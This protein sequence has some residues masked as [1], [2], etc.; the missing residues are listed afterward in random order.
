[1]SEPISSPQ[2]GFSSRYAK[3]WELF[4]EYQTRRDQTVR[5]IS[6]GGVS[7]NIIDYVKDG[8]D[9][10]NEYH[11]KPGWKEDWQQNVFDPKTRDKVI[12]ILGRL[13]STRMKPEI[14]VK[15]LSI[16]KNANTESR[17]RIYS[18]L[19]EAANNKN[20]DEERLIWEMYTGLSEGSVIGFESWKRDTRDVEYVKEYDPDT[21]EK[22]VEKIKY[23]AWDDVYGEIVPID[24][25]YPETI[26]TSDFNNGIKRCF[27]V[28]EMTEQ[29]FQ[30]TYGKFKNASKVKQA[31]T[32]LR[33][34]AVPWGISSDINPENIQVIHFYDEV[35]DKMG[36]WANTEELYFGA[37]PWNHKKKPFWMGRGEPIHN[38]YLYGKSFP[39]K[40]MGMQDIDNAILNGM[41]DELFTGLNSPT[42]ASGIIDLEEGYLEPNRIYEM[43]PGGKVEKVSL[44]QVNPV[45]IQMLDLVRQSMEESS[46]SRQNQ[47]TPTGGR[48]TKFEVQQLQEGAVNLAGMFLTM[49]EQAIQQKYWLRI[50]NIVQYYSMPSRSKTGKKRFKFIKLDDRK[51]SN[52]KIGKKIIQITDNLAEAPNKAQLAQIAEGEEGKPFDVLESKVEPIVITR[53]YFLNKEFDLEIRI[54]ANSSIKDSQFVRDNKTLVWYQA[55]AQDPLID[56]VEN[57]KNFAK[58]MGQPSDIVKEP[59]PQENQPQLPKELDSL[60]SGAPGG[61]GAPAGAEQQLNQI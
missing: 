55:T 41:L 27:W 9:R 3:Y 34:N 8:V 61:G 40:L 44:G 4:L 37:L 25:F 50:H 30:D 53:D 47:G 2:K 10:M 21:G 42:F 1:M 28:K 33:E 58:A 26:W 56:Q 20:H 39:D 18:D 14:L 24:E 60:L 5:F 36:I 31:S 32:F 11:L 59:Q 43:E 54:V 49:I 15:S 46:I 6:K 13:A 38:Q 45:Q 57:R 35:S 51:L 17:A 7:R 22:K 29:A 12:A 23:D 16:W 48:K 52:G 19:L